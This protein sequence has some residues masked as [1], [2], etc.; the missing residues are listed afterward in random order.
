MDWMG[1]MGLDGRIYPV[2]AVPKKQAGEL[3]FMDVW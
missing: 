1:D 3:D 2:W